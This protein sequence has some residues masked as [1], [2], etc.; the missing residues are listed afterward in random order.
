MSPWN[1]GTRRIGRRRAI[2]IML[3]A[4]LLGGL[5]YG[6]L[7]S[8]GEARIDVRLGEKRAAPAPPFRLPLLSRGPVSQLPS[9]RV[10]DAL[11]ESTLTPAKLEG[12]PV[13]LNFWASWCHPCR[14]EAPVL[15]AGWRRDRPLGVVYLG[16]DTE[17]EEDDAETFLTRY[18]I[19]YPT[20]HESGAAVARSYGG[21]GI[22]E[23]YFLDPVGKI[24]AHVIGALNPETLAEGVTAARQ[25]VVLGVISGGDLGSP[26]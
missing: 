12:H 20:V 6:L 11:R 5:A 7:R 16:V 18:G 21:V 9:P 13:V 26:H 4:L 23:T 10:R 25:G 1:A 3:G 15:A 24:V 14:E 19:E 8:A 22:P 17:D 2:W